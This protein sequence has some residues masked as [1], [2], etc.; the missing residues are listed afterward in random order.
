M[1]TTATALLAAAMALLASGCARPPGPLVLPDLALRDPAFRTTFAAHTAAPVVPGNRVD[2]LLN[3]KEIFPALLAAIREAEHSITYAQ[4]SYGDGPVA[5]EVAAALAERCRAGVGVRV[6]LD[7]IG[8]FLMPRTLVATMRESGCR[9]V[10]ARPP[11]LRRPVDVN[12]RNHRRILVVDGR[13]GFTGGAGVSRLWM[14]DGRTEEHWRDTD[15]RV[16]GPVVEHLQAAFAENWLEATGEVLTGEAF[17]P[18]PGVRGSSPVQV[19]RSSRERYPHAMYQM[20]LLAIAAA[21]QSVYLTNPYF[22]P[23]AALT[24]ELVRAV[25]RGV[26][27]VLLLPGTI[28]HHIVRTVS[29]GLFGP[30]LDG[31]I[32][33]Y[34]YQAALLHAKTMVVDGHWATIGSANLNNRS[35]SLDDELNVVVY[36]RA[37]AGRL[38]GV[39]LEDLGHGERIDPV[40]WRRRSVGTRVLHYL[41]R[42]LHAL[43]AL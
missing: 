24:R 3:G 23:D 29:R 4:Y 5:R 1:S 39:F 2:V 38:E 36:D 25:R 32:E 34:E 17:F 37:V 27:V 43:G 35:F 41:L 11:D 7:A 19:V 20:Y 6:L 12:H 21:R 10:H 9:V 28:D 30:L 22:V 8:A 18:R 42:P 16:E 31:G 15:V 13:L 14:G 40:E 26:R 33:I